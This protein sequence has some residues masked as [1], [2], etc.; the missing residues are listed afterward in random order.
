[1]T[2]HGSNW[3]DPSM[4]PR[5]L[6]SEK[7]KGIRKTLLCLAIPLLFVTA[8]VAVSPPQPR[9]PS[10][11]THSGKIAKDFDRR[12]PNTM[13]DVIVQFK[14]TPQAAH[15]RRMSARGAMVKNRLHSIKAAS[16]RL[17]VSALA[18]L[19]KD[20]DVLYISP[21]RKVTLK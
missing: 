13:V 4:K 2:S 19:E 1:M 9:D 15:Y 12:H 17:P 21:D 5:K 20:P 16:F 6:S 7:W 11:V 10:G 8:S 3:S 18:Q 14:V